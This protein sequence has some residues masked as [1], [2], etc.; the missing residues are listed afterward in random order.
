MGL[1][2]VIDMKIKHVPVWLHNRELFLYCAIGAGSTML[3][4]VLYALMIQYLDINYQIANALSVAASLLNGFLWNYYINF[5]TRDCFV[6][7]LVSFYAVGMFGWLLAAVQLW[8]FVDVLSVNLLYSKLAVIVICTIV[9]FVLNKRV[10]FGRCIKN[11]KITHLV[12]DSNFFGIKVGSLNIDGVA[13]EPLDE[14]LRKADFDLV[15]VD[16]TTGS[17]NIKDVIAKYNGVLVDRKIVMSKIIGAKDSIINGSCR[18]ASNLNDKLMEL[19]YASGWLSRF[20]KDERLHK[21]FRPMYRAWL[22]NDFRIGKVF[23]WPNED[24]V[25][26]MATVHITHNAGKIG[27][28]AVAGTARRQGVGRKLV[29]AVLSWLVQQGANSCTVV[30]Q[31]ENAG[32]RRLYEKAGFTVKSEHDIYHVW[33]TK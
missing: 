22:E 18:V 32:A 27:L 3:D 9:Q 21:F 29:E 14:A 31:G 11:V 28:V 6:A 19:A 12:W 5:K 1:L 13:A 10:T 4:F 15:Y 23:V 16:S 7:R 26:G 8:L 2:G 30:T 33:R 24:E 17:G 20:N 25:V